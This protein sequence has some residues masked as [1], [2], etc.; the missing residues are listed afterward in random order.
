MTRT[1]GK[2]E[3]THPPVPGDLDNH[4]RE[5]YER[6]C[7]LPTLDFL[8]LFRTLI[9]PSRLPRGASP[10]TARQGVIPRPFVSRLKPGVRVSP[11]EGTVESKPRWWGN[12]RECGALS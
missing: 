12:N 4:D 5:V 6:T 8:S 7:R 10:W 9:P 11:E 2:P 3:T 1:R